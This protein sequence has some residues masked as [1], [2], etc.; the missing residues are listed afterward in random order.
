MEFNKYYQDELNYLREM[1][2]EFARYYPK[3]APYLTTRGSDPDVERLMEGFAFIAGRIRQKL[4]DELPELTEGMFS[5][6]WPQFMRPIPSMSILEFLPIAGAITEKKRIP[7]GVEVDSIAI[8]GT[9]CRFRTS[10]DVDLYP[11]KLNSVNHQKSGTSSILSLSFK[12]QNDTQIQDI[13]LDK[14]RFYLHGEFVTSQSL[15]LWLCHYVEEVWI[16]NPA[17]KNKSRVSLGNKAIVGSGFD[18]DQQVIEYPANVFDGYRI[19]QEYFALPQKFLFVDI[20][21][22]KRLMDL[23]VKDE[24]TITIKFSRPLDAQVVPTVSN[25]RMFCTPIVNLFKRDADPIRMTNENTEY[26]VRPSA[27]KQHHYEINEITNVTG[28]VQGTN[29]RRPYKSFLSFDHDIHYTHKQSHAFFKMRRQPAV[30]GRGIDSYISFVTADESMIVGEREIVSL[31]LVCSNRNL[32]EKLKDGD[33]ATATNTSPQFADF[34]NLIAPTKSLPPPIENGLSWLLISNMS[35]NY[36][37]LVDIE[38]LKHIFST[39]NFPAYYNLQAAR[40]HE[41]RMEGLESIKT[42]PVTLL[43]KGTPVRG[44]RTHITAKSSKF[45]CEGELY[46]LLTMVERFMSMYASINSFNQLWVEDLDKGEHYKWM[47]LQGKQPLL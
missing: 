27:D 36:K 26:R 25:F 13:G 11:V 7:K 2:D 35:L 39:Y 18:D 6:L 21:N 41:L 20:L 37:S 38:S 29:E 31:E 44:I 16:E 33:I 42:E 30:V 19:L 5:L 17:S 45:S 24:F 32:P 9:R 34:V 15:Y 3:L 4:D 10:Y 28:W 1:G 8:E 12:T 14:L 23:S 43:V 46:L 47:P 40:V 22:L